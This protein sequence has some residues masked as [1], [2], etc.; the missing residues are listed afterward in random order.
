MDVK[1]TNGVNNMFRVALIITKD[2]RPLHGNL[3]RRAFEAKLLDTLRRATHGNLR[4]V[5]VRCGM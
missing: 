2:S 3:H 1:R 4:T 5:A